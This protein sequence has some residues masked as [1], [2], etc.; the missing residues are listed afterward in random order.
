[1]FCVCR[2]ANVPEQ[3]ALV[4]TSAFHETV[5]AEIGRHFQFLTGKRNP[6]YLARLIHDSCQQFHGIQK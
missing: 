4:F 6:G 2:V 5:I 3:S 1:M